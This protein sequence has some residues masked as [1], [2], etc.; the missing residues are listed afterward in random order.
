MALIAVPFLFPSAIF[1][2]EE[3]DVIDYKEHKPCNLFI[4]VESLTR[5]STN[6]HYFKNEFNVTLSAED[7]HIH[8]HV[9]FQKRCYLREYDDIFKLLDTLVYELTEECNYTL[10]N[11]FWS[12]PNDM[13]ISCDFYENSYLRVID[14][15]DAY[16]EV[17][18]DKANAISDTKN[19]SSHNIYDM[20]QLSKKL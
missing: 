17:F 6:K 20:I 3:H 19:K 14:V 13:N 11:I 18:S 4:D 8:N 12:A 9:G 10:V 2:T 5:G 1:T 15:K 16:C 7:E